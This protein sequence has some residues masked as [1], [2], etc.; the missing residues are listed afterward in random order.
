MVELK[1]QA[2]HQTDY[3]RHHQQI[4]VREVSWPEHREKQKEY[5]SPLKILIRHVM[6]VVNKKHE[7]V[8]NMEADI[9]A[10]IQRH[11]WHFD[12][13]NELIVVSFSRAH[14]LHA[15]SSKLL[16]NF[17]N[18]D[19]SA[20]T[21]NRIQMQHIPTFRKIVTIQKQHDSLLPGMSNLKQQTN[22]PLNVYIDFCI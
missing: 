20:Y 21:D 4:Q 8:N 16:S 6:G 15:H 10:Q 3:M 11:F 18:P 5:L 1:L 12:S 14:I 17:Y 22:I 9:E 2:A 7:H 13:N 19:M